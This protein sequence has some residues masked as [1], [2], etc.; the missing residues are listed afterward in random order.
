M[1]NRRL[2]RRVAATVGIAA[3]ILAGALTACGGGRTRRPVQH[4]AVHHDHLSV[5][6][7]HREEH[8]PHRWQPLHAA[9]EGTAGPHRH[10]RRQLE[11]RDGR[12]GP[13]IRP[14]RPFRLSVAQS[15]T[16]APV[17]RERL[18]V[19]D[20][21]I[22]RG[23]H[24]PWIVGRLREQITAF[25]CREQAG[26]QRGCVDVDSQHTGIAHPLQRRRQQSPA[27]RRSARPA[28]CG[29]CRRCRTV[30]PPT[31][32]VHIPTARGAVC[33][34]APWRHANDKARETNPPSPGAPAAT[35]GSRRR[36]A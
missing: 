2:T 30:P 4:H 16:S 15:G 33:S 24:E 6:L 35:T 34:A 17:G 21:R 13:V 26:G 5:G 8:Q 12:G 9:R 20:R 29:P 3:A 28:R 36:A 25:D 14:A 19:P 18:D 11:H 10:P 1:K 32:R 27:I 7:P 31:T 23:L 22:Q